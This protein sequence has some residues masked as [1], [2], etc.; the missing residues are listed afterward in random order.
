MR[1]LT[2]STGLVEVDKS[3]ATK[4]KNF[5][6]L[7]DRISEVDPTL[8]DMSDYRPSNTPQDCP[9]I[10]DSWEVAAP[11]LPPTP[12]DKTCE[13]MFAELSCVPV[14]GLD[15]EQYGDIFDYICDAEGNLCSG[16][17]GD[18]TEGKYGAFSMCNSEQK[19]GHVLDRYYKAQ[20]SSDEACDFRGQ[21][22]AVNP[23]EKSDE[24]EEALSN[25]TQGAE[26]E[27]DGVGGLR[28]GLGS[29]E[30]G[31]GFVAAAVVWGMLL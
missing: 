29:L 4:M 5:E 9:P 14:P 30:V 17:N 2:E 6:A 1:V 27:E 22:T 24:C 19:L 16:I 15:E 26:D 20:G 8:I 31:M 10:S 7:A 23:E 25:A 18:A 28:V 3:N 13:C 11:A 12:D 21:A